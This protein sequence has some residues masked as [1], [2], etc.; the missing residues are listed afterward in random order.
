MEEQLTSTSVSLAGAGEE[1]E[2]ITRDAFTV[3]GIKYH[4]KNEH[5]EI[6]RIWGE[7]FLGRLDEIGYRSVPPVTYGVM[8][9]YD[10]VTGEFDYVAG[11]G[12]ER[13][14][15]VPTGMVRWDVPAQRYAVFPCTLATLMSTFQHISE[16]WLPQ[17]GYQRAEGPELEL[18]DEHFA[19]EHSTVY[20]YIPV[21]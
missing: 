6:K 9:N 13:A 7:S 14:D 11:T 19:G 3:V 2:L 10:P 8:G 17:S 12:V 21:K 20:V 1:P 5:N 15:D 18:Y 16:T 4:G